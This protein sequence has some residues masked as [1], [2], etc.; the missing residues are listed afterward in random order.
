MVVHA[1]IATVSVLVELWNVRRVNANLSSLA[2]NLS[3]GLIDILIVVHH[4][5]AFSALTLL[6]GWQEGHPACK[7]TE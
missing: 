6:V 3:V 1:N 7:K 2:A 4:S 5:V